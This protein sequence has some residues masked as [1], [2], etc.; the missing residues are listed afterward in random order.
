MPENGQWVKLGFS[1]TISADVVGVAATNLLSNLDVLNANYEGNVPPGSVLVS[2][3]F[4]SKVVAADELSSYTSCKLGSITQ[5]LLVPVPLGLDFKKSTANLMSL[6]APHMEELFDSVV[7]IDGTVIQMHGQVSISAIKAES[8][9]STPTLLVEW[10]AS[11][12]AGAYLLI[13]LS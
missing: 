6:I 4:V 11:P 13:A 12:L 9:A 8:A 5:R 2:E 1:K 7:V 10:K 3:N